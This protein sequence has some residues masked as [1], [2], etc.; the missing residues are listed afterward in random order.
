VAGRFPL[1]ADADLH[2]PVVAALKKAGWDVMRA[3][4]AYP[5]R[6]LDPVHFERAAQENRVFLAND[7]DIPPIAHEWLAAGRPF[8]GLVYWPRSHYQSMSPGDFV[9]EF[10][11]LA[12]ADDPFGSYPI[13]Y[14][15]RR[16]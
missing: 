16:R 1:Y 9:R 11:E 6:T 8:R 12:A 10:A 5:E 13:I 7:S 4:D 15:K 3:I 2:G 14:L